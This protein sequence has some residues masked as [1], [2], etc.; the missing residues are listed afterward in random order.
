MEQAVTLFLCGD[1]MTGRGI[2]QVMPHPGDPR[3]VEPWADSAASYVRIAERANGPIPRGVEP[4]YVWGDALAELE[5]M[6]PHARIANLETAV[7]T[8]GDA[9]PGKGIHYRMHPANLAV[10]AAA[11]LDCCVLANNHVIDWGRAGLAETL[12]ALHAAGH[13][14]AGAGV[15]LAQAAAP[16]VLPIGEGG[17]AT[18][19]RT[20]EGN[21]GD[22]GANARLLVF[23]CA[24][25]DSG[26]PDRWAAQAGR[27]GVH[28]LDDLSERSADALLRQVRSQARPGDLV[29]LSIHW[30]GNWG[31]RASD[32]ERAFAHRLVDSGA[33]HAVHGHSSHHPRG[34]E[35][36]GGRLILYG[37]GDLINDYEGI[38]GHESYRPDLA[39][40]YFPRFELPGGRLVAMSLSPVRRRR[41]RLERACAR[42]ACWLAE[43]LT[44]EGRALGTR[45]RLE[46]DARLSLEWEATP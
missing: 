15:D 29:V 33:V 11:R 2:D 25:D 1:V 38:E 40:M 26:V 21:G 12:E 30:G 24:T 5:R 27:S 8:C 23:A 46:A 43:T 32:V 35:V 39:L 14:T 3:L 17:A 22:T 13:R 44:R 9:W 18:G 4:A 7:T 36:R 20:G 19:G 16:A 6:R 37:C 41:F 42:D 31:Y 45:V 34:I 10:L 28:L